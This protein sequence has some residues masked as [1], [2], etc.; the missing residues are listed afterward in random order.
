MKVFDM[1]SYSIN[2]FPEDHSTDCS[3]SFKFYLRG[4]KQKH[5]Q[6]LNPKTATILFTWE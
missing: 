1:S 2:N 3:L 6:K 4:E 5:K